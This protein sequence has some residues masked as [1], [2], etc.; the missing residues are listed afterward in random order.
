VDSSTGATNALEGC[1]Y[2][3]LVRQTLE[4][5]IQLFHDTNKL[6]D[7]VFLDAYPETYDDI[8]P[9][10]SVTQI[11]NFGVYRLRPAI[12]QHSVS[13]VEFGDYDWLREDDDTS[14]S[15]LVSAQDSWNIVSTDL[16]SG[17]A[18]NSIFDDYHRL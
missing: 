15:N 1:Q 7:K 10:E 5:I 8:T 17:T 14:T 2:Q 12:D 9:T 11:F 6:K 4:L 16:P 18:S 3:G 13:E